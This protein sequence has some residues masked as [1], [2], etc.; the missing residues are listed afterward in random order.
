MPI[1]RFFK[2]LV[3]PTDIESMA[4]LG[5]DVVLMPGV[6]HFLMMEDP[7]RFNRL[8]SEVID[9]GARPVARGR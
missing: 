3:S 1:V 9:E 4:R 8:L 5:V 7:E 2:L 6:G